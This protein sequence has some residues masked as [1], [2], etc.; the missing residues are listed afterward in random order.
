LPWLLLVAYTCSGLAGLVYE[1]SWTRLLTLYVGH[2]TAAASAVVGAFLGG[3]AVGAAIGGRHAERLTPKQSLIAYIALELF[4]AV[5]AALVPLEV[6]AATPVLRWAYADGEPGA[7][8][9]LVRL[10]TCFGMV[11]IPALA[12]GATFPI[13]TRWFAGSVDPARASGWLYA[14]N[15]AGAATGALLAGFFLIPAIGLNATLALAVAG[16][17]LAAALVWLSYWRGD[18]DR[19][20]AP[21]ATP[22]KRKKKSARAST[23]NSEPAS[24]LSTAALR[25]LAAGVLGV[26]GFASLMHEIV[27]TRILSLLLGPTVYAFAAT[28]AAVIGGVAVGSAIAAWGVGRTR[29]PALWLAAVLALAAL[30][31]TATSS[32]AGREVPRFAVEQLADASTTFEARLWSGVALTAALI[33]P[34]AVTLGAAFPLTLAVVG[35]A[36]TDVS[37]RFGLVYAIN[38][39]GAVTGSLASGFFF[40]PA[41]GLQT[42]L[43]VVSI[44]LIGAAVAVIWLAARSFASRLTGGL[45]TAA[46]AVLLVT[47]PGWDRELLASGAY[48]YAPFVP[49]DLD[50]ETQLKAGSLLYYREGASSTVSVKRLTGTTTLAVDGKTDASNRG[51]MLTQKLVAHLPLLLHDAPKRVGIV[52]L[53]SGV[54]LGAALSHPV[55]RADVLEIS[56]EVVE[57]SHFFLEE[58]KHALADPRTNLIVGDGRSHLVLTG[59]PYDVIISEPSNPWIAGVAALFTREFFETARDRLAPGGVLCQWANAYTISDANLRAIVATF[60]SVFPDGTVWLVG[61]EDVLMVG[62][63]GQQPVADRLGAIAAHWNR[64]GVA[65]DLKTVSALEPFSLL[66]LYAGGPDELAT[67]VADAV[68]L[69]D[70]RMTLEF[71]GPREI[72]RGESATNSTTLAALLAATGGPT[73]V[74]EARAGATAASWRKRAAMMSR[75]DAHT[76]AY[77]DYLRALNLDRFD[78]AALEGFVRTAILL[79][80]GSEALTE[81]ASLTSSDAGRASILVARSKLLAT[82]GGATEAMAAARRAVSLAPEDPAALEQVA[83]LLADQGEVAQ[84]AAAVDAL[85]AATPSAAATPYYQGVLALLRDQ[86][87]ETV[88]FANAAIAADATYAPVYDLLG[89]AHTKLGQT[90]EARAA[91]ETSL[92]FDARDSTAYTNL[93]LLAL[94]AGEHDQAVRLF[95]EALWLTPESRVAREG[96]SRARGKTRK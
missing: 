32:L 60:G 42:T 20:M 39:I 59:E 62:S 28:L 17:L 51:D 86:P 26:T 18:L 72:L 73:V 94:A 85:R 83:S 63:K 81:I 12:L 31:T 50:L 11:F 91:F 5:A 66:S 67:Y 38:T 89:A 2:T 30:A 37:K 44:C 4:V 76:V 78:G 9:P 6:R 48:L 79:R 56:P 80:R 71:T 61:T 3:L 52:G 69:T 33:F 57:A 45:M 36:R 34:T 65:D 96:L 75:L 40:I 54:T 74:R 22:P 58:N 21:A 82:I 16:S 15:T 27:W 88:R 43:T 13:A 10:L 64:P 23:G 90:S 49:K 87:A 47:S 55:E 92:R 41:L 77:D 53:G 46:A 19:A 14:L 7:L 93:G 35:A 1:V 70:D 8:F 68:T 29:R 84:L 25:W 95:A 24:D